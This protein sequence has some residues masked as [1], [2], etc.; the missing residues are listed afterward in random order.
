MFNFK[1]LSQKV[2]KKKTFEYFMYFYGTNLGP[3]GAG[4]SWT[5][6]PLFEQTLQRITRHAMLHT[7]FQASRQSG[8]EEDFFKFFY[9]FSK[10]EG[11]LRLLEFATF[12]NLVLT[13]ALGPHKPS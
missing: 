6:R 7:K 10:Y 5:Q 3:P 13:N 4:P 11:G 8:S 12:N 2:L 1:H 9:V